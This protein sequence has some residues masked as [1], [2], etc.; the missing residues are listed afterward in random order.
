MAYRASRQRWLGAAAADMYHAKIV[1]ASLKAV[2]MFDKSV[3]PLSIYENPG[4]SV[5]GIPVGGKLRASLSVRQRRPRW[6]HT[7]R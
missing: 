6:A 5:S 3:L 2:L 4:I 1:L 7:L